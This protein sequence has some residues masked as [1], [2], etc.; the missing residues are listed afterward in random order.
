VKTST[1]FA[2]GGATVEDVELMA[3]Y[4][5]VKASGGIGSYEEAT[6]M[7]DA[8]ADRIGASSGV[9]IVEGFPDE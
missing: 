3:E 2:D 5:P 7:L 9:A 4:L 1:G 8:G 6:A